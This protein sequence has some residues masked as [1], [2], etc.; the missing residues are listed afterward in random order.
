MRITL[1]FHPQ[2]RAAVLAGSKTTTVRTRRYGAPGD[3]F[4][5]DVRAFT[6]TAVDMMPLAAARDTVWREEGMSSPEEFERTWA[7]NHPARGFRA[8]D[9]VWVHRFARATEQDER[10]NERG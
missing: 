9:A 6:L 7:Q 3:T 5:L 4:A 2:W 10:T 8:S 1:P